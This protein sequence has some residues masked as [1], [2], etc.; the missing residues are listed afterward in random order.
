MRQSGWWFA[1]VVALVTVAGAAVA[2]L[3]SRYLASSAF[4]NHE[5]SDNTTMVQIA[6]ALSLVSKSIKSTE[7]QRKLDRI[8]DIDEA[9]YQLKMLGVPAEYIDRMKARGVRET[10]ELE[11]T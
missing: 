11:G 7:R 8:E 9:V 6:D 2:V 10:L 3:D 5:A 1:G 4:A